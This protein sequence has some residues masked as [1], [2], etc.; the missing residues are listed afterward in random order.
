MLQELTI[1]TNDRAT[2][3]PVLKAAIENEKKM[4]SLGLE[5]TQQRLAEYEQQ[6]GMTSDQFERRLNAMEVTE[7]VAFSEWRMEIGML[8]LLK[9][10]YRALQEAELA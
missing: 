2:L 4:L 1:R 8:H 9:S 6:Y 5:R 10:Q 7:T 3:E